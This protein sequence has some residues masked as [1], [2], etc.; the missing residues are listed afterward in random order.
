MTKEQLNSYDPIIE[1]LRAKGWVCNIYSWNNRGEICYGWKLTSPR[2]IPD[3]KPML[4]IMDGLTLEDIFT[5]E[6]VETAVRLH[7]EKIDGALHNVKFALLNELAKVYRLQ[8]VKPDIKVPDS[9]V[10]KE[11][12]ISL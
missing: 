1:T 7:L 3:H 2:N 8:L 9:V 5:Q 11:Q 12:E 4:L 10:I 6:S